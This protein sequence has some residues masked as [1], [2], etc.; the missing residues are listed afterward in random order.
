MGFE[1]MQKVLEWCLDLGVETLTVY[2]F[3]ID[4]FKRPQIEV[5][6]LMGLV[7]TRFRQLLQDECGSLSIFHRELWPN[8]RSAMLQR[9]SVRVKIMGE[10]D[11]LPA[12]VQEILA[13]AA[14]DSRSNNRYVRRCLVRRLVRSAQRQGGAQYCNCVH[15]KRRATQS[16]EHN[17][18]GSRRG[19]HHA[20]VRVRLM[21]S[22]D[23]SPPP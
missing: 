11:M 9:R 16:D 3:S 14:W 13:K 15:F 1:R 8:V 2:A 10:I 21:S 20:R 17:E 18:Q 19:C 23:D 12:D 7:R 5:D 6:T 4:N 22:R